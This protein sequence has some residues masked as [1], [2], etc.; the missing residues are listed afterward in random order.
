MKKLLAFALAGA[1]LIGGGGKAIST[2]YAAGE[3]VPAGNTDDPVTHQFIASYIDVDT[4]KKIIDDVENGSKKDFPGYKW[5]KTNEGD[6]IVIYYYK[7][8]DED[9]KT[10]DDNKKE[11]FIV[12]VNVFGPHSD[13]AIETTFYDSKEYGEDKDHIRELAS[14][15]VSIKYTP[16]F[17]LEILNYGLTLN[18]Y[19]HDGADGEDFHIIDRDTNDGT[20]SEDE[21]K[22][23]DLI[24]KL[25]KNTEEI[26]KI[27][28]ENE[29]NQDKEPD[30]KPDEKPDE[31]PDKKPEKK[32]EKKDKNANPKTGVSGISMVAGSL[33]VASVAL[34][35]TKK[36]NE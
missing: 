8:I 17:S 12:T 22:A 28:K 19:L 20:D 25:N 9:N 27:L 2:A 6:L 24:E 1:L 33:A 29:A 21:D 32:P 7:K 35:A 4:G 34:V 23:K 36:K 30:K 14:S 3:P 15:L 13:Q 18:Y 16:D 10:N 26:E 11:G 31:K 5:V